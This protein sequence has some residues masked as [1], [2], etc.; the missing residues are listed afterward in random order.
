MT[1]MKIKSKYRRFFA[2][3]TSRHSQKATV[4][5]GCQLGV[6]G[7]CLVR[8]EAGLGN[9]DRLCSV[10]WPLAPTLVP[11]AVADPGQDALCR[12]GECF[13]EHVGFAAAPVRPGMVMGVVDPRLP[14]CG[15]VQGQPDGAEGAVVVGELEPVFLLDMG[16]F[17]VGH[18][19]ADGA[20]AGAGE[21]LRG[22]NA[23]LSAISPDRT[24]AEVGSARVRIG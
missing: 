23:N 4:A 3:T 10:L 24:R 22:L 17:G 6:C 19:G 2:A 18:A 5:Q 16:E 20:Q 15:F 8:R 1:A 21:V 13:P 12:P 7:R 11:Y 14:R 9:L